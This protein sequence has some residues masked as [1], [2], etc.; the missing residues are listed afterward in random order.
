MN[1]TT[2]QRAQDLGRI[3]SGRVKWYSV[4]RG[5]GFLTTDDG[6]DVF[7]HWRAIIREGGPGPEFR[8]LEIGECVRFR[9]VDTDR[10]P[11][12]RAV[13]RTETR[14]CGSENA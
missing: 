10:G 12:A 14:R 13:K 4:R 8:K 2:K 11:E 1:E 5:W 7:V 9:I 3:A 6:Q